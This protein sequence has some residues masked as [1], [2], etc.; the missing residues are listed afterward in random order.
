VGFGALCIPG[1][2]LMALGALRVRKDDLQH[3]FET[4]AVA[5]SDSDVN[6]YVKM[7]GIVQTLTSVV[8]R[9]PLLNQP[10]AWFSIRVDKYRI[11]NTGI[12]QFRSIG[13]RHSV[14]P[15]LLINETGS[16]LIDPERARMYV[17]FKRE[18]WEGRHRAKMASIGAGDRLTAIGEV[19]RLDP[20]MDGP[21]FELVG[22]AEAPLVVTTAMGAEIQKSF[23]RN[24]AWAVALL[25][26]GTG[27]LLLALLA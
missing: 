17:P 24:R 13:S 25:L 1:L 20:P 4:A 7:T 8:I 12:R 10:C 9:E 21:V 18:H 5:G 11:F 3:A 19:Q 26:V 22:T 23:A 6:R 16:Y 2:A 14:A 27:L 15:F